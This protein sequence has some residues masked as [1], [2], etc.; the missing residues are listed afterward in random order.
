M[1]API[2]ISVAAIADLH[3]FL[4]HVASTNPAAATR[5][6]A[7]IGETLDLIAEFPELYERFD[8][9]LRRAVVPRWSLGIF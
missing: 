2:F 8:G 6:N 1:K 7:E 9:N 3:D 5:L 4:T